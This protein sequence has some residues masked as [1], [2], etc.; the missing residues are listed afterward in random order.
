ADQRRQADPV[1]ADPDQAAQRA[2]A[3]HAAERRNCPREA[4]G[5]DT[6]AAPVGAGQGAPLA[7]GHRWLAMLES[8]EATSLKEIAAREGVDNR[9]VSRMVNLARLAPDI[10]AALLDGTLRDHVTVFGLAVDPPA[11]WD[12]QHARIGF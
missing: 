1:G 3:G 5:Y 6:D 4:V 2:Q 8:G 11:L 9:C 7:R 12:E 10:V